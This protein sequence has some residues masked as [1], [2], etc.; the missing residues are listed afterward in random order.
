MLCSRSRNVVSVRR[1]K[2]ARGMFSTGM[3]AALGGTEVCVEGGGDQHPVRRPLSP[4][5]TQQHAGSLTFAR[6]YA[7]ARADT[8]ESRSQASLPITTCTSWRRWMCS[9]QTVRC[10][11]CRD[12]SAPQKAPKD[13]TRCTRSHLWPQP[14]AAP[15]GAAPRVGTPSE[16]AG[17]GCCAARKP[18]NNST[19]VRNGERRNPAGHTALQ[20]WGL[21]SPP[22]RDAAPP[23]DGGPTVDSY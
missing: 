8:V 5:A 16:K 10:Q 4:P 22:A 3:K 2:S 20:H 15:P 23:G 9:C 1:A 17:L 19:R 6:K 7:R 13:K 18:H 21:G 12:T 14:T 11:P